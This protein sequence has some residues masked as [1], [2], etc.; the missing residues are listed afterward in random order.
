M[1]SEG[2]ESQL[3]SRVREWRYISGKSDGGTNDEEVGAFSLKGS[4]F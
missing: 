3:L 4:M 2:K 1:Q